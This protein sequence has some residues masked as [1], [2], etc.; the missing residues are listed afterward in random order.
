MAILRRCDKAET[1]YNHCAEIFGSAREHQVSL[2]VTWRSKEIKSR[3]NRIVRFPVLA[4][5][6]LMLLAYTTGCH[7]LQAR[8]HLNKGV[9]AYKSQRYEDAINHF[10]QA[11]NLDPKLPMARLY[12]ATAYAQQVVPD[13]TTPENLKNAQMAID[14]FQQVLSESP[15]DISSLK[16]VASLYLN[17]GK[18][19]LAKEWQKKILSV[20]PNDP[21][22]AYTV[23]VID[24]TL[25]RRNAVKELGAVGI[26]DA[27]DG[28]PKAPKA[29]CQKLVDE[30]TPLVNEGMDYLQKAVQIRPSYDDAMAYIN[31]MYRRKADLECGNDEA[32]KADLAQADQW[33]EKTMGTRKANEEKKNQAP[34]GIVMDSNGNAK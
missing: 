27:G 11:V 29:V 7:R 32:R 30:N 18:F 34:G 3:M 8:D 1:N 20:D 26:Q 16:G 13:L 10:Q 6:M 2:G 25:A 17:T 4:A 33:R 12:L 28:N 21:E 24:W 9:Q 31:L 15:N 5:A 23:G 14:G 22:A 19:D